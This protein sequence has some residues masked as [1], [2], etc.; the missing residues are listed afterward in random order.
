MMDSTK[1]L[2]KFHQRLKEGDWGTIEPEW[3]DPEY[4]END[5]LP[6]LSEEQEWA[7]DLQEIVRNI[8]FDESIDA[9]N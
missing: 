4:A 7:K 3:F 2:K 6:D 1:F 8:F 5:G 9:E